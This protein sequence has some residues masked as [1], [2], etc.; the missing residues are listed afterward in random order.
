MLCKRLLQGVDIG[1]YFQDV[2]NI[3]LAIMTGGRSIF[4]YLFS[5]LVLTILLEVYLAYWRGKE[6]LPYVLLLI[7]MLIVLF[8][9]SIVARYGMAWEYWNI[10]NFFPY[11]FTSLILTALSNRVAKRALFIMGFSYMLFSIFDWMGLSI[12]D[13]NKFSVI[14]YVLPP[15]TRISLIFGS[16]FMVLA[17][18]K[19]NLQAPAVI[20]LI[21]EYSLGIYCFFL[22]VPVDRIWRL[23]GV[24]DSRGIL[25]FCLQIAASIILTFIFRKIIFL[26]KVV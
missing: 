2:P 18:S 9:P 19:I 14:P 4:Y 16:S 17:F 21:S 3:L 8:A 1:I 10:L 26:K 7:S 20:R 11:V 25:N 13:W 23:C 15:H 24:Q 22:F 12:Y 5:L 6:F